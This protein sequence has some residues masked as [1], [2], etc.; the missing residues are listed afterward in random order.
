MRGSDDRSGSLFSYVDL[1]AQVGADHP[2]R[3]IREIANAAL[4]N[5]TGEFAAL[6]P[7]RL[8]R[9]SIAPER[10]LRAM[11]LQTFYGIRSERERMEFDFL[12]RWFVGLGVDDAAWD[13]SSFTKN[14]ERLLEGEI[15]RKFLT[16]VVAQPQVKRLLS[17]DHF[18]VDST[19]LEAWASIKSFRRK[20]GDDNDAAGPSRNAE[21]NF[22]GECDPTRAIA[23]RQIRRPGCT[24]RATASPP[25]C[26]TSDTPSWRTAMAWWSAALRRRPLAQPNERP[27]LPRSTGTVD[28]GGGLQSGA[29]RPMT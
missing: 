14:R 2:L 18:S 22:H 3:L 16:A 21:R 28:R 26:V 8:G 5:L 25:S 17:S 1:E 20:D 4:I 23:A 10:L 15:A 24:R 6:Y 12:F 13:H 11:L 29:T 19:L 27:P 7:V 9:P